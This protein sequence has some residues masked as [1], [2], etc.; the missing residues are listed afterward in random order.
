ME[1]KS[2]MRFCEDEVILAQGCIKR[3]MYKILAG[4]AAVYF[5]YG[6]PGEYLV[7]VLSE[8]RCFGELSILCGKPS[9]YTVVALEE[10]LI[11]CVTEATFDDFIKNN[12]QNAIGIMK[13]L[14]TMVD[15]LS[16]NLNMLNE[17]LAIISNEKNDT[18]K[19]QDITLQ[20][21]QRAAMD[22]IHKALFSALV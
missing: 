7:G 14:A 3:E 8:Q 19:M 18:Q 1:Q 10:V 21:R 5:H 13:N 15:T 6:M 16:L 9:V 20:I 2:M 22:S 12:T 4:K 11:L 17:D